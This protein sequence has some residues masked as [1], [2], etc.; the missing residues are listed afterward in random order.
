MRC[1]PFFSL[2][3]DINLTMK[4]LWDS[5]LDF[6]SCVFLLHLHKFVVIIAGDGSAEM[7]LLISRKQHKS[8]VIFSSGELVEDSSADC[9]DV[10]LCL[11][12]LTAV[13]NSR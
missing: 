1:Q 11:L 4:F 12:F 10:S 3:E 6:L 2:H 13:E 7:L 5:C 8:M 9:A